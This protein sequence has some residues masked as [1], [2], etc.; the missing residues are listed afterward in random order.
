LTCRRCLKGQVTLTK[1]TRVV[2]VEVD[3]TNPVSAKARQKRKRRTPAE[4]AAERHRAAPYT[5]ILRLEDH[6]HEPKRAKVVF[7]TGDHVNPMLREI[8]EKWNPDGKLGVDELKIMMMRSS[9]KI[10]MLEL[11]LEAMRTRRENKNKEKYAEVVAS[12]SP[13][14]MATNGYPAAEVESQI[15]SLGEQVV[16]SEFGLESHV[17]NGFNEMELMASI[18][19]DLDWSM[20]WPDSSNQLPVVE[21]IS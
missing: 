19:T 6:P 12:A 11:S 17:W 4:V 20:Y 3:E 13:T 10:K 2:A 21:E 7:T 1:K 18:G 15:G 14:P 5:G 9:E 8:R 16:C